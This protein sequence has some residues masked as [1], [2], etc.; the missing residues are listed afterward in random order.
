MCH[1]AR[2]NN[3]A[4]TVTKLPQSSVQS[5]LSRRHNQHQQ[6]CLETETDQCEWNCRCHGAITGY[7]E[8]GEPGILA[9]I[10][11][12]RKALRKAG[13]DKKTGIPVHMGVMVMGSV[14]RN[15]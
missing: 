3:S 2:G 7:D 10:H 13:Q 5:T 15:G 14:Y 9:G 6:V 8:T 1:P 4:S 12:R 11:A